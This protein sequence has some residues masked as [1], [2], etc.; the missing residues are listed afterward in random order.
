MTMEKPD[1]GYLFNPRGIAVIGASSDTRKIGYKILD[2]IIS[3]DYTGGVYPINPKGGSIS[4]SKVY[5]EVRNIEGDV[6]VAVIS[7]PAKYVFESVVDCADKGVKFLVIITSGFSEIGNIEEERKIVDYAR[8][9]GMR[10]LGPNIFGIFSGSSRL[11]ATFGGKDV[12][13]GNAAIITQSGALGIAMI[14]KTAI[15]NIGLSAMVS[16]GNKSDI[17]EADLLKYLVNDDDTKIILMYIE[18]VQEGGRLVKSLKEASKRKPVIVIKSGRSKRGAIA[19]ASH[20]GSLAGSDNIF[21]K[22]MKQCGVIRAETLDEAFMWVKYLTYAPYPKGNNAVII[23]NGGGVGVMATDA[24][25]KF[26]VHLLDDIE[27]M[28]RTFSEATPDFGS[29]KNPV[30]ITGQ[31]RSSDYDIAME[32]GLKTSKINAVMALYCE[33]AVFDVENLEIMVEENY[34]KYLAAGK[35]ITFA[36]LGGE[37]VDK[38]VRNLQKKGVPVF[39]ET[40][41]AVQCIGTLYKIYKHRKETVLPEVEYRVDEREIERIIAGVRKDDR[42]FLLADEAQKLMKAA[43]IHMPRSEIAHSIGEAVEF[44]EDIGYP[45]V[46]KIV[47]KDIIHKSDAGGVALDLLNR[48]EVMDAYQAITRSCREYKPDAVIDGIEVCEMV[49]KGVETIIGAKRDPS[50]GSVIMF[51]MGGIYVEVLKEVS[52]RALP[53]D[54]REIIRMIKETKAYPLLLGVRGENK[55]DINLV[56]ESIGRLGSLIRACDSITDIEINPLMVYDQGKG[57][58]AVDARILLSVEKESD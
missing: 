25:E 32:A 16:I 56:I 52:F 55:K 29:L 3:S 2:N 30:D 46:M 53:I 41:R 35:P 31:A 44:A 6:D 54:K 7:I 18:G 17:D 40:Y 8:D 11:N 28:K 1:I 19:A 45:V 49:L 12:K 48:E 43:G 47:S 22:V 13:A 14:G 33:T 50:F 58:V 36:V 5:T 51:G 10:V 26:G 9:H 38:A 24:C 57:V 4:N 39:T 27:L 23:T 21:E 34:R 15:E 20:T 42:T 37:K